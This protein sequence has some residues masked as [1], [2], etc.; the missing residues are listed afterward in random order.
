MHNSDVHGGSTA[1]GLQEA[2]GTSEGGGGRRRGAPSP[3]VVPRFAGPARAAAAGARARARSAGSSRPGPNLKCF[4][5]GEQLCTRF[6]W[7]LL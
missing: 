5:A 7:F 6:C 3:A 4:I 1:G 2:Q